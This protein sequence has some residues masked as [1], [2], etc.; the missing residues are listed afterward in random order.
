M[1]SQTLDILRRWLRGATV[2]EY[3]WDDIRAPLLEWADSTVNDI[4]QLRLDLFGSTY[5]LDNDGSANL[6]N[7]LYNSSTQ[8][9]AI[10]WTFSNSVIF[11]GAVSYSDTTT[12][13]GNVRIFS[14]FDLLMYS[15]A[16]TTLKASIDGATGNTTLAGTLG[17]VGSSI[18]QADFAMY[19][20][21]LFQMFSDSGATGT[22]EIDGSTGNIFSNGSISCS[23]DLSIGGDTTLNGIATVGGIFTASDI[24][25]LI[26]NVSIGASTTA[27]SKLHI[28][29][30]SAGS[31]AALAGTNLTIEGSSS[32]VNYLNFL[33]PNTAVQGILWGDVGDND[34]GRDLYD[35]STNTRSFYTAATSRMTINGSGT[36]AIAGAATVG[37]TLGVTGTTTLSSTLSVPTATKIFLDGGSNTSIRE[38]SGDVITFETGGTDRLAIGST[39]AVGIISGKK[40]FLDGVALSGNTSIRESAADTVAVEIGGSDRITASTSLVTF[41]EPLLLPAEDPPVANEA[42][43]NGIMKAWLSYTDGTGTVTA[44]YNVDSLGD[45]DGDGLY[46]INWDTNFDSGYST[47]SVCVNNIDSLAGYSVNTAGLA[48]IAL[49]NVPTASFSDNNFIMMAAGKQ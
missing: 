36:V 6:S 35:H 5:S 21:G 8:T 23:T 2:D 39:G 3:H 11:T 40:I 1:A 31:V 29:N 20:G 25:K 28:F 44:S 43:R 41:T 30:G 13:S 38:S 48:S 17:V 12:F 42:N 27:D 47:F 10:P 14:G 26:G 4:N 34:V 33:S 15:D 37:T 7:P 18:F 49:Y 45:D 16:G 24:S 46:D 22:F 9:S 32:S 19:S